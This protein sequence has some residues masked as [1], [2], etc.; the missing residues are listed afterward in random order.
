LTRPRSF[1][2]Q[3]LNAEFALNDN[4][5]MRIVI[6]MGLLLG[7]AGAL[8]AQT[9]TVKGAPY[10]AE[11]VTETT[12][13][14]ADGNRVVNRTSTKQ[15]RDSEG[16]ERRETP[17]SVLITDPVAGVN[18]SLSLKDRI[19]WKMPM[20]QV[21]VIRL[22]TGA[23]AEVANVQ[24]VIQPSNAASAAAFGGPDVV[25]FNNRQ[26]LSQSAADGP[27]SASGESLGTS[28][29]E[30]VQATGTRTVIFDVIDETWYSPELKINIMTKR[31][32]PRM[33][34]TVFKLTGIGRA[35]PPHSL[36]EVPPGYTV[37]EPAA[38]VPGQRIQVTQGE[39][40]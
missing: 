17:Q 13:V 1:V 32:D 5:T 4:K 20:T 26:G 31:T 12:Q 39:I 23:G 8:A 35:E 33:G 2:A 30:G 27:N 40:H 29:I 24:I 16:R 18:Y 34:E 6:Q 9:G 10:S 38:V 15:Y 7:A 36:F 14:L 25:V 21:Q 28:T 22:G 37:N 3:N 11:A 19:A